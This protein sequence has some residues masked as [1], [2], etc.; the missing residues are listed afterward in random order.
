M[1]KKE[2]KRLVRQSIP[3]VDAEVLK[4]LE[5]GRRGYK[6][7]V[8]QTARSGEREHITACFSLDRAAIYAKKIKERSPAIYRQ[9]RRGVWERV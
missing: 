9:V 4:R 6:Y 5:L 2:I 3:L 7:V 8:L 1:R